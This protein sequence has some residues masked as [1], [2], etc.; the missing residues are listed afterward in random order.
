MLTSI[1]N[2]IVFNINVFE[3]NQLSMNNHCFT[4][5]LKKTN[6]KNKVKKSLLVHG[7]VTDVH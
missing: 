5:F 4:I 1:V 6:S 2:N 3:T 7:T